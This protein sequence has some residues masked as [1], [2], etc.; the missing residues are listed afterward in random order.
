MKSFAAMMFGQ[1]RMIGLLLLFL[2]LGGIAKPAEAADVTWTYVGPA[3][4]T[5]ECEAVVLFERCVG[6]LVTGTF[7]FPD[8]AIA[9]GGGFVSLLNMTHATISGLGYT[10]TSDNPGRVS[11]DGSIISG[12]GIWFTDGVPTAWFV[13]G[14]MNDGPNNV[15]SISISSTAGSDFASIHY[16]I[17]GGYD[18]TRS[19]VGLVFKPPHGT[20]SGSLGG[21]DNDEAALGACYKGGR[22]AGNPCNIGTGNKYETVTDYTTAGQNRLDFTR[23]YNSLATDNTF[24]AALGPRWSS[25]YDRYLDISAT[26]VAAQRPDGKILHFTQENGAWRTKSDVD[27]SLTYSGATWTLTDS[28]DTVETYTQMNS[29]EGLLQ[30]IVARD[31]YTQTLDYDS[32][33]HLTSVTDSYGRTL[34]FTYNGSGQLTQLAT[35]GK[36]VLSYGY[37]A[38]GMLTSVSYNTTPA[39]QQVYSYVNQ[40]DLASI[41]DENGNV[42]ASW[43]YDSEHRAL[44]SQHAD[45]AELVTLSYDSDT[46]RTVTNAL[47]QKTVYNFEIL[48]GVP[49]ITSISRT[50]TAT[51]PAAT[52][53]FTYDANG[54]TASMT[55]WNGNR[56]TYVNDS[57]G[58]PTSIT[59]AAGT[60]QARTTTI[61]YGGPRDRQPGTITAPRLT[62]AFTYDA[63][64]NVLTRTATD[65]SGGSTD[66]QTRAWTFTYDDTGH[67]LTATNPLSAVTTY[68]YEG[69]N[70]ATVTDA[71]GHVSRITSYNGS[72]LPLSMTD[73]NGVETT[74][75]YDTRNRL[76]SRTIHDASGQL[77]PQDAT[78]NFGYDAAG[79]LTAITLPGGAQLLYTYDAAH[80]VTAVQNNA[81]ESIN[82]TLDA[83]GG[84]TQTQVS[85]T[86]ITKTQTAVFDSLGRML[87]QIGAYNETTSLAYDAVG[88]VLTTSDALNHTSTQSFDAL[89]RLIRSVDPL[90]NATAYAFDAQDNLASVTDPRGLVTNYTYNGFGEVIAQSSPDSGT[91]SWTLD[92]AGNRIGETDARGV[93]TNRTF[94]RLDR[95]LTET[96]PAGA[97]DNVSYTYDEGRF[98]IG[99][100]TSFRD[101]SGSTAF[102]YDARGNVITDTRKIGQQTYITS[103]TYDLADRVTG[104]TYPDK[105]SV[106]YTR[107]AVGRISAVTMQNQGNTTRTIVSNVTYEPFGPISGMV[108][109]NGVAA[110][111][112]HDL[113]YRLTGIS[114]QGS[115]QVQSLTMAYDS[116]GDITSI[117]D[118]ATGGNVK[119]PDRG[120]FSHSQSFTYDANRRLLTAVGAYGS[121]SFAY[122]ADGN[123]TGV[124]EVSGG[125]TTS[126][127]YAYPPS[128][129][130]LS[131]VSGSST[132]AFTYTASGSTATETAPNAGNWYAQSFTYDSRDRNIAVAVQDGNRK[133]DTRYLYNA[134]GQRVSKERTGAGRD[135]VDSHGHARYIYDGQGLLLAEETDG[136]ATKNYVYIDGVPVAVMDGGQ[137]HYIHTDQLATPQKMTDERQQIV[138]NRVSKPF[139]ETFSIAGTASLNLRFPGQYHDAESGLDYN[140]FRT[141]SPALGRYTQSDPIGLMGGINTYAY[142]GQNPVNW[143]DPAGLCDPKNLQR[144]QQLLLDM[145][146]KA[147]LLTERMAAY[148]PW[149]DALS[150]W[151]YRIKGVIYYTKRYT[152]YR[153]I[154][155]LQRGI[156][157]NYREYKRLKCDKDDGGPG[158][159]KVPDDVLDKATTPIIP[160]PGLPS[161]NIQPPDP[162]TMLPYLLLPLILVPLFI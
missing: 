142:V 76:L 88:N 16:S 93:V 140:Y 86:A 8:T 27:I 135:H 108:F 159:G 160:P 143:A 151:P 71:L 122:D 161:P 115:A 78:T 87:R 7:T 130:R 149:L 65:R 114:A 134:L 137:V 39:T 127:A 18:F 107:D 60:P 104:I 9:Q 77:P 94:D 128:S 19:F 131:G 30:T 136:Q 73:A 24:A 85:G 72:G 61:T 123:R 106:R 34:T 44:T 36:L 41:T 97:A 66:G 110:R 91:T 20:W 67:M 103:Y 89:N 52:Q 133:G 14:G 69:D 150:G 132:L 13:G 148:N 31:G 59:E 102:A 120:T 153:T 100:L 35:P 95:V 23:H 70:V 144:C 49:K 25:N 46:T 28:D 47:G 42:F 75:T 5:A 29:G 64:G 6:G 83:L 79:N 116:V 139:G 92:A 113:N 50:A 81:G 10:I 146:W 84:I 43:T 99:R 11:S 154:L 1:G 152:H 68:T 111:L 145:Q 101:R 62:T 37:G 109:G 56:T 4:D 119:G 12:A 112:T 80:R 121:Q 155:G 96:Y 82:Y 124:T 32:G 158:T 15:I 45:G 21:G 63:A 117:T 57:N 118:F 147:Q 53:S 22:L 38:N 138:W 156:V 162:S 3:F 54:Y 40:F 58:N 98:G 55:D 126:S 129:N 26:S 51:V 157:K 48:Q 105:R 74:F 90:N 33:M 141:Y 125:A 2:T 17:P